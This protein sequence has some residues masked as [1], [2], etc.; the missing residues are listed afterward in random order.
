MIE[1]WKDRWSERNDRMAR[2][3]EIDAILPVDDEIAWLI[4]VLAIEQGVDRNSAPVGSELDEPPPAFLRAVHF[5]VRAEGEAVD[6]VG[7]TAKLGDRLA[8]MIEPKQPALVHR[9]EEH[10]AV[11]AIPDDAASRPLERPGNEFELPSHHLLLP[12]RHPGNVEA[13]TKHGVIRCHIERAPIVVAP[14]DVGGVP[15]RDEQP[16]EQCTLW[17]DDVHA[18]GPGAIDIALLVALHPVGHSRFAAGEL[19][20]KAAFA[21]A[22][23]R[24]NVEGTDV[25]HPRV[26]DVENLLVRAEAEPVGINGILD[27][28]LDLALRREPEHRLDVEMALHIFADHARDDETTSG[29]GPVHRAVGAHDDV[30]GAVEFLALPARR[31]RSERAVM[32]YAPDRA[33]RPAGDHQPPF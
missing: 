14:G 17:I 22:A 7:V 3:G 10:L 30:V 12:D 24:R 29:I 5:A 25:R 11:D 27:R 9:A 2:I 6:P 8:D 13:C 19:M 32:L 1:E 4:V 33:L 20:E 26:I 16:A 21:D 28:E 31:D 23:I 15:A 18:A